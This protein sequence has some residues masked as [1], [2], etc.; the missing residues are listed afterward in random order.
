MERDKS[1]A[2]RSGHDSTVDSDRDQV[3]L[4]VF[5][6]HQDEADKDANFKQEVAA[7]TLSDPLPT[8]E[9]MSR[10]LGIPVGAIVKYVLVKWASSGSASILEIGP[11]G[12][13]QMVAMVADAEAAGTDKARLTAYRKLSEFISWLNVPL[14]NPD[15]RPGGGP[16]SPP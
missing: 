15:W 16:T 2:D 7:Y 10:N 8:I 4:E 12:V 11:S 3:S 13:Q 1:G 9:T 5:D 14:A 6:W